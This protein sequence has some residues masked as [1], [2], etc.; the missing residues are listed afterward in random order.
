ME[1]NA[2]YPEIEGL[3][4][5]KLDKI[6][7]NAVTQDSRAITDVLQNKAD[8]YDEPPSSDALRE[9]RDQAPDR[10]RGEVTNSTYYY[11]LNQRVKPFDNPQVRQAV[12]FAIDKRA[13]QRLFGG[14]L[15]PSCNFLPP[16]MQGYTKID[17]CP[18]G[19]PKAAPDIAKAKQMIQEAGVAGQS[20]TVYGND[21]ELTRN[22]TEYLADVLEQIGLKPQLR[23]V[24][25][26]VY[27]QTIGNQNTKAAAGFANWFQDYPHPYNFMFLIDGAS[28]QNTNNQNF[29]N[30]DDD[31]INSMLDEANKKDI[32]EAAPEYA[33]VDKQLVTNGDVVPYGNRVLPFIMSD[34]MDFQSA[35]FHPVL[36][37]VYSTFA[38]KG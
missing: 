33:A 8:Y 18:Y 34:K 38:L 2:N 19:D 17:P 37:A 15:T 6:T 26:D 16:G 4:A 29:G 20:V 14:L 22:V 30:V 3:P 23:I 5:A 24:N 25:G 35:L 28:I 21:E 31:K 32:S 13:L 36:Q 11:F 10:Y 7:I 12:N 1:K 9:F 27:F